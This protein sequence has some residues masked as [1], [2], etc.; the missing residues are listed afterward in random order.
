MRFYLTTHRPH[1]LGLTDVPLFV[2]YQHLRERRSFPRALGP[3]A[4]DSGAFTVVSNGQQFDPPAV[5]AAA[6]R[7]YAE[8]VGNLQWC[9]P[10]DWMCEPEV[11]ARTG[12]TVEVHQKLTLH[13]YLA[14]LDED[15]PVIPVLQGWTVADYHRH[16]DLYER[17]GIDLAALPTVGVGSVCQR[18]STS[19]IEGIITSLAARGYR[20]HGFGVKTKGLARY[21]YA[22]TSADSLAWSSAA[23]WISCKRRKADL[24]PLPG[25]DHLTCANCL[26]FALRWRDALLR[27]RPPGKGQQASL[28][29]AA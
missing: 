3:W 27:P 14:L 26:P 13:S 19:E 20:I 7:R 28:G 24:G 17:T 18:E 9:A 21:S 4:L 12:L 22:L 8:E 5:Y 11:L 15:A 6:V 23:R 2:A 25:C 1:W 16:A 10:Q 29:V